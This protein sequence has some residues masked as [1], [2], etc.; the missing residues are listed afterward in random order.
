MASEKHLKTIKVD[1]K[2]EEFSKQIK[3]LVNS[4]LAYGEDA[5]QLKKKLKEKKE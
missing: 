5:R 3:H 2:S 1:E 4:Y